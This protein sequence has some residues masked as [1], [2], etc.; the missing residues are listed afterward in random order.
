MRSLLAVLNQFNATHPWSHNDAYTPFV[1]RHARAVRRAGGRIAV[2]VGCGTGNLAA[3]FAEVLP[4]VIGIEPDERSA[5]IAASRFAGSERVRIEHRQFGDEPRD[6]YDLVVFVAS[7]HHMPLRPALQH[8]REALRPSGRIVVVA[9]AKE[10]AA[11]TPRSLVSLALNPL[12]GFIR[13]PRRA[14]APPV[15][16]LAPTA[17]PTETFDE[18]RTAAAEVLPGIRFRRRLFWRYTGHWTAPDR[19]HS[20]R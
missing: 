10:T 4:E 2:D 1:L 3:R 14:A 8:A 20:A 11:D 19:V 18:V 15:A 6:G 17:E 12:V 7:L 5:S 16:M 9:V 13:H